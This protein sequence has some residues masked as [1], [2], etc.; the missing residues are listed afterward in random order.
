MLGPLEEL[1]NS[2]TDRV[3]PAEREQLNLIQRNGIRLQKLVIA[4]AKA[5]ETAI[6]IAARNAKSAYAD[7]DLSVS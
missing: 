3:Q 1:S 4:T 2:L 6:E 5:I 7:W